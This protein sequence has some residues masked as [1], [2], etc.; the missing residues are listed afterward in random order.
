[1]ISDGMTPDQI[2]H[3]YRD[4]VNKLSSFLT[5]LEAKQG[6]K[7]SSVYADD[8]LQE[9]SVVVPVYDSGL[10]N[11]V[12]AAEATTFMDR[13][14]RYAYTRNHLKSADDELRFIDKATIFQ[15]DILGGIL[16]Y[17]ILGGRTKARLWSEGVRNGVFYRLVV[18]M[19][20]LVEFWTN[21]ERKEI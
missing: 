21:A 10:M 11:F 3:M 7:A 12:K 4:D 2:L 16:S 14:Y 20:E 13:N 18:K 9:H 17:Y 19:K 5:Y 15:M 6:D 8:G 1:M